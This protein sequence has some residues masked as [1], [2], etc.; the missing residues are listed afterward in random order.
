MSDRNT[1]TVDKLKSIMQKQRY[2]S[3]SETFNRKQTFQKYQ[4]A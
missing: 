4:E 2:Y 1:T 3:L